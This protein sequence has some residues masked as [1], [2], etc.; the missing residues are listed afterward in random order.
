MDYSLWSSQNPRETGSIPHHILATRKLTRTLRFCNLLSITWLACHRI[1]FWRSWPG[2]DNHI[3]SKDSPFQGSW[4][5]SPDT[6]RIEWRQGMRCLHALHRG[7]GPLTAR[8]RFITISKSFQMCYLSTENEVGC[9]VRRSEMPVTGYIHIETMDIEFTDTWFL[10]QNSLVAKSM[11]SR[12][13]Q[14]G[15]GSQ[16]H[17]CRLHLTRIFSSSSPHSPMFSFLDL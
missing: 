9:A 5:S 6:W 14:M 11:G 1:S 3:L 8:R 4:K 15:S 10:R 16:L 17:I 2:A 13:N 12:V 7:P